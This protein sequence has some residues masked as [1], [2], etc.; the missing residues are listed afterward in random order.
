MA[1]LRTVLRLRHEKD[2]IVQSA[3]ARS[4]RAH[5]CRRSLAKRELL[6][7]AAKGFKEIIVEIHVI[8]G[9]FAAGRCFK[10][11]R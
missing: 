11:A 7:H 9:Q 6:A 8:I 10:R 3:A 2:R 5:L 1:A 4:R